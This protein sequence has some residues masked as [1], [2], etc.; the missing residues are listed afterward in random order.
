MIGLLEPVTTDLFTINGGTVAESN[1]KLTVG[2]A[3]SAALSVPSGSFTLSGGAVS[4]TKGDQQ[5]RTRHSEKPDDCAPV[6][7]R[8]TGGPYCELFARRRAPG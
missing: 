5:K 4:V 1:G 6:I 7:E 8:A 2:G 3:G